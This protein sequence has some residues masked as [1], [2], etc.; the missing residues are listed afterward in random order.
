MVGVGIETLMQR[1]MFCHGSW[2]V[3]ALQHMFQ[4]QKQ[5]GD[6]ESERN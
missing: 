6:P 3:Q 1:A 5:L 2:F 4:V